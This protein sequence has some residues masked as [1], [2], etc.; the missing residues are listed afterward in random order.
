MALYD[1]I[2]IAILQTIIYFD[3]FDFPLTEREIHCNLIGREATSI[4]AIA[5]RLK[6]QKLKTLLAQTEGFYFLMGKQELV[7]CR[8][9]R[10]Q[11]AEEKYKIAQKNIRWLKLCPGVKA[12]FVTNKLAYANPREAGDIDLAIIT[13]PQKLWTARFWT[14]SLMKLLG[15]RPTKLNQT[16]KIC[17]S[18]Y[19]SENNLNLQSTA[20][21]HDVHLAFW[22]SQFV[23]IFDPD[24]L[25]PRILDQN[26]WIKSILPHACFYDTTD[27][28]RQNRAFMGTIINL[29]LGWIKE[30]WLKRLQLRLMALTLK[31]K[32]NDG[33]GDV[34]LSDHLLKLHS[35]DRRE[36]YNNKWIENCGRIIPRFQVQDIINLVI[37]K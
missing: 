35:L 19:L 25:G 32:V 2:D 13:A 11:L 8:K 10:Y 26:R 37:K 16:N 12:I 28:R 1:A 21:K 9:S 30:S 7:D 33:T 15:R 20:K 24:N 23:P 3:L 34:V 4:K 14:T 36:Y 5:N 18:F 29:T 27:R 31:N 6:N 22:L 17:L